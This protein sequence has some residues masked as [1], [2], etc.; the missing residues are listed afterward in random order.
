VT[1]QT[2]RLAGETVT[3]RSDAFRLACFGLLVANVAYLATVLM[4]RA[5]IVDAGGRPI[6]TDF[7]SVYAAGRL[8]LDG[9]PAAA[10]DWTLHYMAEDAVSPHSA[11]DYLGWHYPPPFLMIA[12]LLAMLPYVSAFIAWIAATLP[13]YLVTIRT[14]V[15]DRIGWLFAGAFPCLMPNIIPGQNGFLT[16]ALIGGALALLERQPILAGCCLGLL[17]YK[18]Q[19]GILFPLLLVAGGHWRA[20]GAAAATAIALVLL[21][22]VLFGVAPWTEFFHWLPLTSQALFSQGSQIPVAWNKF[23]SLYA[24]VRMLGGGATLAWTLQ[25]L[26]AASAAIALCAMWW[27]NRI[28][29]ELK[30]AAA[31]MGVLLVTPYVYIYDLTVLAVSAAFLLRCAVVAGFVPSEAAGLALVAALFLIVPF[32]GVPVGLMGAAILALLIARRVFPLQ[33]PSGAGLVR[34]A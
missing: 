18:P 5:W 7:T 4:A 2:M 9:Q 20:I 28:A 30:A 33:D 24:L 15:G 34:R 21:T 17:T 3:T 19:F 26:L 14:I 22:I 16:A 13:L 23:Q 32:F 29:Y 1:L 8:V 10:Y 27:S 31:A 12:A 25:I 6:H 11:I